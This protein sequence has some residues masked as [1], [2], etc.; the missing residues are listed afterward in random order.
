LGLGIGDEDWLMGIR[1]WLAGRW[2]YTKEAKAES[3]SSLR[4][5]FGGEAPTSPQPEWAGLTDEQRER[6][7]V[8]SAWVYSDVQEL[9]RLACQSK[10]EV[11]RREG[12]AEVPEDA[13]LFEQ[14][15]RSPNPHMGRH[16]VMQYTWWWWLLRG[17]AY[18]LLA[19]D[20]AGE[21]AQ[22][23]PLPAARVQPIPD[24]Q[25]YIGGYRY[26]PRH[27]RPP[28]TLSTE[29]VFFLRFPNPFEFHRGLSPLSAFQIALQTDVQAE[30]WNLGTFTKEVAVRT[31]FVVNEQG[32]RF[33]AA[34][35]RI[36]EDLLTRELR[37]M[38]V[39]AQQVDIKEFG[40]RHKDIEFLAT[41]K[42]SQERIDRAYGFPQGYWSEKA[43]RATAEQAAT[44]LINGTVW[45]LLELMAEELTSQVIVPRYGSEYLV[46]PQ[47]IRQQDRR[48]QVA[49][50]KAY[51]PVTKL[52]EARA[53]LGRDDYDG[54][55]ADVLGDL[56]VSL[57]TD[58]QFVMAYALG[59]APAQAVKGGNGREAR[60]DLRRWRSIERRRSREGE[61]PGSY[62]FV[63]EWLSDAVVAE[64]KAALEGADSEQAIDAVFDEV[65]LGVA[66]EPAGGVDKELIQLAIQAGVP[67]PRLWPKLGLGFSQAE[68]EE[69]GRE[70]EEEIEKPWWMPERELGGDGEE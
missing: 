2:G 31:M 70:V 58:P 4:L 20:N 11:H 1:D 52:N 35:D 21:L 66:A 13:H 46:A 17:E 25:K 22:V 53:E 18:W 7:A 26:Y 60:E 47:D 49:E 37:Y 24:P 43:N 65:D 33:E 64:V 5:I 8:T 12:E 9:T 38:I 55:L 48:L 14:L 23:Y 19:E 54:P 41:T 15:M 32:G 61:R 56:P 3:S 42:L 29:Q 51:W 34:A 67:G 28:V 27:G 45:P 30:K 39:P 68:L 50:R 69:M 44:T 36:E 16:Y 63:S 57:A 40:L 62:D 10:L 6:L 59:V